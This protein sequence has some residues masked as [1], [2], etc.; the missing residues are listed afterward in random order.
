MVLKQIGQVNSSGCLKQCHLEAEE[1]TENKLTCFTSP[2]GIPTISILFFF[3]LL[4]VNEN[5][6]LLKR[7]TKS[8]FHVYKT[9]LCETVQN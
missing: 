8:T 7:K 4:L 2:H 9:C 6:L 3:F 5:Q 1:Q